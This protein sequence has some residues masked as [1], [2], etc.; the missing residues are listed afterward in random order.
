WESHI[1]AASTEHPSGKQRFADRAAAVDRAAGRVRFRFLRTPEYSGSGLARVRNLLAFTARV[2]RPSSTKDL[3][4]PDVIIGSTVHPLAAWAAS[5]VARRFN[6][7]FVFEIRDL[8]PQTLID[9]GKIRANSVVARLLR[10]LER[11]LC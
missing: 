11:A 1:L 10:A 7:P 8:W 4:K 9:M 3:P 6:V 5:V 2:L